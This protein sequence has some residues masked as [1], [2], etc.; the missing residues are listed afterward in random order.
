[1]QQGSPITESK[2]TLI[3]LGIASESRITLCIFL[4]LFV[5]IN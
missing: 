5:H 3:T 4:F 1:M 2:C